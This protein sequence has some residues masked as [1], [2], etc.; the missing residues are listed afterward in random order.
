MKTNL[1]GTD[2]FPF[3]WWRQLPVVGS[4]AEV[5]HV[6]GGAVFIKSAHSF[7]QLQAKEGVI[8]VKICFVNGI[9]CLPCVVSIFTCDFF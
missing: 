7:R 1:L 9:D 2:E 6:C 8:H 5:L 4:Q 3:H